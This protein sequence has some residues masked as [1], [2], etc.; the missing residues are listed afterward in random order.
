VRLK[1]ADL[2]DRLPVWTL[3]T[4]VNNHGDLIGVGGSAYFFGERTFLLQRLDAEDH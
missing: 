4:D 1:L 2:A 3:I